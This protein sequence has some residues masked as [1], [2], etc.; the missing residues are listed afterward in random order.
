MLY[1]G[2]LQPQTGIFGLKPGKN[3]QKQCKMIVLPLLK[4]K[5]QR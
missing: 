2:V 4:A 5:K 3:D 1:L